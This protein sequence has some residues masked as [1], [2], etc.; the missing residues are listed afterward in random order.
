M[1]SPQK[2]PQVVC[3]ACRVGRFLSGP[4]GREDQEGAEGLDQDARHAQGE[5]HGVQHLAR[6]AQVPVGLANEEEGH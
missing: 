4:N 2:R 1:P 6:A 3:R 5:A